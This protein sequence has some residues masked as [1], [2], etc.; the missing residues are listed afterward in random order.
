V[1]G[2]AVATAF[3]PMLPAKDNVA[4]GREAA[5][6]ARSGALAQAERD[7]D[8]PA[9][10]VRPGQ[11]IGFAEDEAI[12]VED[13]PTEAAVAVAMRLARRDAEV[14]TLVVGAGAGDRERHAVEAALRASFPELLVEVLEGGQ[15]R[16]PFLIGIE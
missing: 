3:N 14:L 12:A 11:W 13:A 16:Y 9:G 2:L 5:D 6:R 4:S 8:T 7:A 1:A 15:P 10:P